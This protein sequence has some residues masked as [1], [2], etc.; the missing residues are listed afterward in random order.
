MSHLHCVGGPYAGEVHY[1]P[2]DVDEVALDFPPLG[3]ERYRVVRDGEA[4][5]LTWSPVIEA[6]DGS[7]WRATFG[8][9]DG[10]AAWIELRDDDGTTVHL[11]A[12]AEPTDSRSL[13]ELA[14]PVIAERRRA[15]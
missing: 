3:R 6:D 7:R 14:A 10:G 2:R 8:A 1:V 13:R 12:D 15:G 11:V 5:H 9:I 4:A